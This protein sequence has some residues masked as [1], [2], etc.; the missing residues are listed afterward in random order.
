MTFKEYQEK[1]WQ[2]AVYP[3]KG[4]NIYYPALGLGETGETQNK[5]KKI[6]RDH[7]DQITDDMRTAIGKELGDVLWY[8]AAMCTELKIS[9]DDVAQTNMDKLH[10]RAK[11]NKIKGD[12]DD[13]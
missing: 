13:R 10:S 8:V 7:N 3:R 5:V 11:R 12:G 2:V 4:N 9:M 1:A 6:M